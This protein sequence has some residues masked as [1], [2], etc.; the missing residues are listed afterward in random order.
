[1]TWETVKSAGYLF[2]ENGLVKGKGMMGQASSSA[3]KT[4]ITPFPSRYP[5]R[6]ER[7]EV[8]HRSTA[9]P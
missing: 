8:Y 5:G 3:E 9:V 4:G 6:Y 7:A 2:E 1:M